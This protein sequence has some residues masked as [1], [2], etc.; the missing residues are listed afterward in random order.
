MPEPATRKSAGY[1]ALRWLA[2]GLMVLACLPHAWAQ[3]PGTPTSGP[4]AM[5]PPPWQVDSLSQTSPYTLDP[6]YVGGLFGVDRFAGPNNADYQGRVAVRTPTGDTITAGLVPAFGSGNPGNGLWNVGL[7]RYNPAGQRVAWSNPG[8]HGHFGDNY[9]IYPGSTAPRYQYV[10]DIKYIDG[11]IY[12]M[13]DY[14]GDSGTGRQDVHILIFSETGAFI[15]DWYAFGFFENSNQDHYGGTL[16]GV[17]TNGL[18]DALVAVATA[19]GPSGPAIVARRFL[20]Q[21]SGGLIVDT[22]FGSSGHRSYVTPGSLC[23]PTAQPCRTLA[24]AAVVST[25]YLLPGVSPVYIVGS[26]NYDGADNWDALLLKISGTTGDPVTAFSGDGWRVVWFDQP[27]SDLGD[28]GVGLSVFRESLGGGNYRTE[29]HL[30]AQVDRRCFQGIGVAKLDDAGSYISGF[31]NVEGKFVF[32]GYGGTG[33]LCP[34]IGSLA[35]VAIDMA[36]GNGRLGIAGW[37]TYKDFEGVVH[38][39]PMLAVVD[40]LDGQVIGLD[41]YPV[42]RADG[43]RWG[44]GQLFSV[45]GR[46]DGSFTV[47]GHARDASTTNQLMYVT[48]RLADTDT[49]FADDFD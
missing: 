49:I 44:E 42:A 12:V 39:N 17:R 43:T 34:N 7:V 8:V 4:E 38:S 31:G 10:R 6:G 14:Q 16:T 29:I 20:I 45:V 37:E 21:Q 35:D 2:A 33:G 26:V 40:A 1:S 9:V 46:S 30:A 47:A 23:L 13:A 15:D 36:L 48:G 25:G 41:D 3:A 18:T 32:G 24:R 11:F 27:K 19:Y 5:T 28:F 22:G